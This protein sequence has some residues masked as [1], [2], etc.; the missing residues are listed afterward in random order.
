MTRVGV[1][2]P[3]KKKSVAVTRVLRSFFEKNNKQAASHEQACTLRDDIKTDLGE[4][5]SVESI[6]SH[7]NDMLYRSRRSSVDMSAVP[8]LTQTDTVKLETLWKK[9]SGVCPPQNS[10]IF[11]HFNVETG[12]S[13]PSLCQWY[14]QHRRQ[15]KM[16]LLRMSETVPTVALTRNLPYY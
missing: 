5:I 2:R 8:S 3:S 15:Y 1:R 9:T 6:I 4:D 14:G 12:I 10:S 16:A 13:Y 11:Q 7:F